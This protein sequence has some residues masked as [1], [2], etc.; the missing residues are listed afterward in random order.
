MERK[1]SPQIQY[2]ALLTAPPFV[3][4]VHALGAAQVVKDERD[5]TNLALGMIR[6]IL[7]LHRQ[8]VRSLCPR[9]CFALVF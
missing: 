2:G 9:V 5:V 3:Y 1:G 4:F 8:R 6:G 7:A